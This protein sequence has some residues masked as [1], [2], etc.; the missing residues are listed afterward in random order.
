MVSVVFIHPIIWFASWV[1]ASFLVYASRVD[2]I[3][4]IL[5]F[6]SVSFFVSSMFFH[7]LSQLSFITSCE[8][9][10]TD[11]NIIDFYVDEFRNR[12][13][14]EGSLSTTT[15]Q[16][17]NYSFQKLIVVILIQG[18]H[19]TFTSHLLLVWVIYS[20]WNLPTP[21]IEPMSLT[22]YVTLTPSVEFSGCRASGIGVFVYSSHFFQV[23]KGPIWSAFNITYDLAFSLIWDFLKCWDRLW[24]WF[25]NS[26]GPSEAISSSWW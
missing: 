24:F 1:N 12:L 11:I 17:R 2:I 15:P 3:S 5:Y 16:E 4:D 19:M 9:S 25:S 23:A 22:L 21:G 7:I 6:Y 14:R 8:A 20:M 18:S 13:S 26:L 10:K